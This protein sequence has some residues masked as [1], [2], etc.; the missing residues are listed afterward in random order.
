[1][2]FIYQF[3]I[4]TVKGMLLVMFLQEVAMPIYFAVLLVI[5]KLTA[6]KPTFYAEETNNQ[7][8]SLNNFKAN[9]N[10]TF[11]VAPDFPDARR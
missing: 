5:L 11:Y 1:M 4:R 10:T 8:F 2:W 3:L 9:E 6:F 7:S